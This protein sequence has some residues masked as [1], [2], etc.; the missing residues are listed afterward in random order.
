MDQIYVCIHADRWRTNYAFSGL[1]SWQWCVLCAVVHFCPKEVVRFLGGGYA[2]YNPAW[3]QSFYAL[4]IT[5][6]CAIGWA[7]LRKCREA[8]T[9]GDWVVGG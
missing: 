6:P 2:V 1:K 5:A 4:R 8:V 9:K 3:L 7:T